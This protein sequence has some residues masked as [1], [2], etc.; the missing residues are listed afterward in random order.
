M[1]SEVKK[2][3]EEDLADVDDNDDSEIE[4]DLGVS[5]DEVVMSID[6]K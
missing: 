6:S 2:A 5:P 4:E 1:V 3:Y